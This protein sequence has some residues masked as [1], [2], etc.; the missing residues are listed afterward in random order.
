[1]QQV[2]GALDG[3]LPRLA[4]RPVDRQIDRDA[5]DVGH[6]GLVAPASQLRVTAVAGVG[7]HPG[8]RDAGVPGLG[9]HG[10]GQ[11]GLGG[12]VDLFGYPG[13][14]APRPVGRPLLGQ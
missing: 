2:V 8:E 1:M 10:N 11:L 12:E 7:Q 3:R 13:L 9:E 5:E 6:G 14:T 4:G